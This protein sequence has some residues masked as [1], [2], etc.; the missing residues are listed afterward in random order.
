MKINNLNKSIFRM[1]PN[2]YDQLTTI[3]YDISNI[4]KNQTQKYSSI[5]EK[6]VIDFFIEEGY[7]EIEK[8]IGNCWII[9][10]KIFSLKNINKAIINELVSTDNIYNLPKGK[11][12]VNQIGGSQK[13]PD[14]TLLNV[15][16]NKI[17][18]FAIECKSCSGLIKWND[19]L[20]KKSNIF[21][22][23]INTLTKKTTLFPGKNRFV[24]HSETIKLISE[25][26]LE[27]IALRNK[28]KEK[29]ETQ[30]T[31]L[32]DTGTIINNQGINVYPRKNFIQTR[33]KNINYDYTEYS[34][35]IKKEWKTIFENDF[36]KFE[37]NSL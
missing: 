6:I 21:Y 25:Y 29:F 11:Y 1:N 18:I 9:N 14:A 19:N 22:H 15:F 2:I 34:N 20:P 36:K 12:V 3:V 23:V 8:N 32:D 7:N 13:P 16:E 24:I 35:D 4:A 27:L 10:N 5:H 33:R 30:M 17:N 37:E 28:F 26:E 31:E